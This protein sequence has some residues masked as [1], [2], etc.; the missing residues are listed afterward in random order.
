MKIVKKFGRQQIK[1]NYN[2][3]MGEG[4]WC[5]IP[6]STKFQLYLGQFYWWRKQEYLEKTT[7]LLQV[8]DKLASHKVVSS[9]PRLS[10]ILAHNVSGDSRRLH[11]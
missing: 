1:S 9:T 4:L 2:K 6:L 8:T 7:E 3:L 5:L 10:G 11:R